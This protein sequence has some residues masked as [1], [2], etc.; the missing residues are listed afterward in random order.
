MNDGL[1]PAR[2]GVTVNRRVGDGAWTGTA[3]GLG[4]GRK[5]VDLRRLIVVKREA[6]IGAPRPLP[7]GLPNVSWMNRQRSLSLGLRNWS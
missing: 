4:E 1:S 7:D 6:G 5:W 2:S 3:T